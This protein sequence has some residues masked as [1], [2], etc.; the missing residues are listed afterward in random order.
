MKKQFQRFALFMLLMFSVI[1]F[2]QTVGADTLVK[3][4]DSLSFLRKAEVSTVTTFD[5]L[6]TK[7]EPA[8]SS[9]F[10]DLWVFMKKTTESSYKAF[11]RYLIVKDTFPIVIGLFVLA[12][13]ATLTRRFNKFVKSNQPL[14]K[15]I[16]L[17]ESF[18]EYQ[19]GMAEA[20]NRLYPV[21]NSVIAFL[22]GNIFYVALVVILYQLIPYIYN[23][24]QLIIAPEAR[25]LL[26]ITNIYKSF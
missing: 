14:Y 13:I 10:G 15:P 22:A 6:I 18:T 16:E 11:V 7:Y 2:S 21:Y 23:L 25:V 12:L 9:K 8:I 5:G 19:T 3:S 4:T 20:K 24:T 26:E 17:K 1:V